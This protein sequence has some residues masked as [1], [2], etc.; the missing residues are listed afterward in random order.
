M[1]KMAPR[2]IISIFEKIKIE[3][4]A[5]LFYF[6]VQYPGRVGAD[7]Q[8]AIGLIKDGKSTGNWTAQYFWTLKIL[9]LGGKVVFLFGL[10]GLLT[11][12]CSLRFLWNSLQES[13]ISVSQKWYRVVICSPLVGVYGLTLDHNLQATTG[14]IF[15]LG[16]LFKIRNS[17]VADKKIWLKILGAIFLSSF[18]FIGMAGTAGFLA[19][20]LF[21]KAT[22]KIAAFGALS[23]CVVVLI[24]LIIPVTPQS[25]GFKY[26]PIL[27]D[28]KCAMQNSNFSLSSTDQKFL[29]QLGSKEQWE[30]KIGCSIPD[31]ANFAL[32]NVRSQDL[33]R[34][35]HVWLDLLKADPK[36]VFM[37]HLQRASVALPPLISW[38]QPNAYELDLLKP[39][40]EGSP[41]SLH[42]WDGVIEDSRYQGNVIQGQPKLIGYL[43]YLVIVPSIFINLFSV[44][45]GWGGLWLLVIIIVFV[46]KFGRSALI[47][48][49]PFFFV[50]AFLF[51]MI[52]TPSPRY[53]YFS[54]LAGILLLP[55]VLTKKNEIDH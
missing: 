22:K 23:F 49:S 55:K 46:R 35:R 4:F 30:S 19:S 16:I 11:L 28:I 36:F 5:A 41:R 37:T 33:S 45:W 29:F 17:N 15:L 44:F 32:V 26:S 38:P 39:L 10:I 54:I 3:I 42:K 50:H 9:T 1:T 51:L 27:E 7:A 14:N 20:T 13:K 53:T 2:E 34:L 21:I 47:F 18:S 12:L 6:F 31:N 40:G 25:P 24:N 48:L 8:T 43:Q 52:P